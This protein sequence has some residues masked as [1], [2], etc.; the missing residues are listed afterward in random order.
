MH[1]SKYNTQLSWYRLGAAVL[2]CLDNTPATCYPPTCTTR[3]V[4]A[5]S[6][7]GIL[8]VSSCHVLHL[9]SIFNRTWECHATWASIFNLN[10]IGFFP[11]ERGKRD[12]EN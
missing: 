11:T 5:I 9:D 8:L 2:M 4:S 6:S 10:L 12:L 7:Q 3:K 1:N